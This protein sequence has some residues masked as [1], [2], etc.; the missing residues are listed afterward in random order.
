M[1]TEHVDQSDEEFEKEARGNEGRVRVTVTYINT[2]ETEDFRMPRSASLNQVFEKAY[3]VLGETR[4]PDD[5]FFCKGGLDLSPYLSLTLDELHRRKI[6]RKR[7]YEI[8]S[9]TGG[10]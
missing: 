3:E 7:H 8:A 6:C 5:K 4:R 9:E 10:A 1:K 2:S